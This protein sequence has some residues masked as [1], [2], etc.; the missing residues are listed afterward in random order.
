MPLIVFDDELSCSP[1]RFLHV[2][3]EVHSISFQ[4]VCFGGG[5]VR[6][7]IEVKVL[8][9]VHEVDRRVFLVNEFEVKDLIACA[10]ARV[11]VLVPKLDRETKF[12]RVEADRTIPYPSC[13]SAVRCQL[14]S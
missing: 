14:R 2:L 5:I 12:L 4:R 7:K 10:N 3:Y 9:F 6:S 8:A 11:K 1:G 13:A